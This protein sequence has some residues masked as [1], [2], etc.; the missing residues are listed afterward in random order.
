[1]NVQFGPSGTQFLK[2]VTVKLPYDASQIPSGATP[3]IWT[4]EDQPGS[5]WAFIGGQ[6][7]STAGFFETQ[8][9]HFSS[10]VVGVP[11][12]PKNGNCG[13]SFFGACA[14]CLKSK[15]LPQLQMCAGSSVATGPFT[16][17]CQAQFQCFCG[18]ATENNC[19][20]P[21]PT[22]DASCAPCW[23]ASIQ[24]CLEANCPFC[25]NN[26]GPDGG[27]ASDGG[28]GCNSVALVGSPVA[29]VQVASAAPSPQGGTLLNGTYVLVAVNVYTGTGGATG[30]NGKTDQMTVVVSNATAS[31]AQVQ[32][33]QAKNG[34]PNNLN[35]TLTTSGSTL[36]ANQTCPPQPSMP[37][38][39]SV[40]QP[41]AGPVQ[42]LFFDQ[43]N[44]S[45][46]TVQTF[47]KQ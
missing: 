23:N 14:T 6:P 32:I 26:G 36:T 31:G 16:G 5:A 11:P 9:T 2:P 34:S 13:P 4:V 47:N 44:P 1:V 3:G 12:T 7:S 8:T 27:A 29:E 39:Y 28:S 17:A 42:F 10:C 41:T 22:K 20:C 33:A 24:P 15:C 46:T 21:D 25:M 38:A 18:C 45:Q 37:A 30:S 40:L 35:A 19:S 43:S